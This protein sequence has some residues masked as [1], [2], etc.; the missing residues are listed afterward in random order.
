MF[1][2]RDLLIH[3]PQLE[4]I[5]RQFGLR[6]ERRISQ[7]GLAGLRAG[8]LLFCRT[9][10]FAPQI[11][12]PAGTQLC[13]LAVAGGGGCAAARATDGG[14]DGRIQVGTCLRDQC[15]RLSVLRGILRDVLVGNL[16]LCQQR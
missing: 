14:I 5:L 16:H 11:Q 2:E 7:I 10:Q 3:H 12:L 13:R 15:L 8:I 9:A 4:I 6:A 1:V